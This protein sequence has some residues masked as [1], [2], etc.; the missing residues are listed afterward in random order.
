MDQP[1]GSYRRIHPDHES[2]ARKHRHRH[3]GVTSRLRLV[4][5]CAY[6]R[7]FLGAAKSAQPLRGTCGPARH[8]LLCQALELA[9]TAYLLAFGVDTAVD[10]PESVND[11]EALWS[12]AQ[13]HGLDGLVRLTPSARAHLRKAAAYYSAGAMRRPAL[14]EILRGSSGAP[15][16]DELDRT[17]TTVVSVV[18]DVVNAAVL[19]ACN[20]AHD[21]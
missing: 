17:A 13:L 10:L 15:D 18:C 1:V 12:Q 11:L 20:R 9:L 4:A 16:F 14:A 21:E 19:Q 2:G 3:G 7:D 6:A 8:Y 5:L